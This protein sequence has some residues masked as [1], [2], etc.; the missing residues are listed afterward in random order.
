MS[1]AHRQEHRRTMDS[2]ILTYCDKNTTHF[3]FP[4]LN[5]MDLHFFVICNIAYFSTSNKQNKIIFLAARG[6]SLDTKTNLIQN[7]AQLHVHKLQRVSMWVSLLCNS[8]SVAIPRKDNMLGPSLA[9]VTV[10]N[11]NIYRHLI[12]VPAPWG[13]SLFLWVLH[14]HKN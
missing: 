9:V 7:S 1:G 5:E 6:S 12:S 11:I 4:Q 14:V 10:N 3:A 2:C 13:Q 8:Y